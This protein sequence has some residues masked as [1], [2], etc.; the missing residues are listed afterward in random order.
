MRL[1]RGGSL[2]T[3][4]ALVT[5]LV[6]IGPGS[7]AIGAGG[8]TADVAKKKC[9]KKK[10][11][12]KKCKKRQVA[13]PPVLT[14]KVRATLTWN[15]AADLDLHIFS[16][17]GGHNGYNRFANRYDAGIPNSIGP[18]D[19]L[20]GPGSEMFTDGQWYEPPPAT[21]SPLANRQFSF[22]VCQNS[23][24]STL[25]TLVFVDRTGLSQIRQILLSVPGSGHSV[26][27]TGALTP[28]GAYC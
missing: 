21:T 25:A 26:T 23:S 2:F 4:I 18:A 22:L 6:A 9:K 13:P 5:A 19:L 15:T 24:I 28:S 3:V 11:K 27:P 16:T 14:S 10:G 1:V 17:A 8:P 20:S 7:A 12:K